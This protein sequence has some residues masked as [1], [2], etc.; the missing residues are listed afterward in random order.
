MKSMKYILLVASVLSMSKNHCTLEQIDIKGGPAVY[1]HVG[2]EAST[3]CFNNC[4]KP[5]QGR[6]VHQAGEYEKQLNKCLAQCP[7]TPASA[8][9]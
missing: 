5:I 6:G 4:M 7:G 2:P 3:E 1:V 9:N 8:L